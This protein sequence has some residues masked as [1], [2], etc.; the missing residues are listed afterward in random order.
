MSLDL[1]KT[2][3]QFRPEQETA[4]K[5]KV[6]YFVGISKDT[7]GSKKISMNLVVIPPG[8]VS[9]PH[10]HK[11]YE[12]AIYMLEGRVETHYGEGLKESIVSEKGDFVYIPAGVP[13]QPVNL[14]DTEPAKAIVSR[15][16][17]DEIENVV[18]CDS[19]GKPA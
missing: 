2:I 3:K 12:T 9:V 18:L 8:A 17:S 16:D 4:T 6:K 15:T 14:S 13:H 5:Q 19:N 11:D 1:N 7:A 10:Y